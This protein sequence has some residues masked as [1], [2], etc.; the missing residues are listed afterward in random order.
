M[1]GGTGS[2]S[3]G[4]LFSALSVP[5][6]AHALPLVSVV[7]PLGGCAG[8]RA[9]GENAVQWRRMPTDYS[10]VS[11]PSP[12]LTVG[13]ETADSSPLCFKVF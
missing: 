8:H 13:P 2:P 4:S 5:S 9:S 11:N 12:I 7:P 10:Q 3:S 6:P 1:K